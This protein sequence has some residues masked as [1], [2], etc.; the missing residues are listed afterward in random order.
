MWG[1]DEVSV[2]RPQVN[3]LIESALPVAEIR[4]SNV[5]VVPDHDDVFA[6]LLGSCLTVVEASGLDMPSVR[7]DELVV[8]NGVSRNRPD[9]YS[10]RIQFC[11]L[12][13]H[14][15]AGRI[16]PEGYINRIGSNPGSCKSGFLAQV[17]RHYTR[18]CPNPETGWEDFHYNRASV[19]RF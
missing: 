8:M 12:R 10:G 17:Q 4:G 15:S 9:R 2:C 5:G 16:H 18:V 1:A 7:N 13:V 6:V 14:R 3:A 11:R 19:H